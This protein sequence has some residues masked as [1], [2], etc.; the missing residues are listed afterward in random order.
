[1]ISP[2]R[3]GN[4]RLSA[5]GDSAVRSPGEAVRARATSGQRPQL[6]LLSDGK[7]LLSLGLRRMVH[8]PEKALSHDRHVS[9]FSGNAFFQQETSLVRDW[10]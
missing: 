5:S 4:R 10:C 8:C 3:P 9:D 6:S 7:S 1:M 2:M